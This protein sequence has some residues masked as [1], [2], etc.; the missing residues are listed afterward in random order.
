MEDVV[1]GDLGL[2]GSVSLEV[3][4]ELGAI[5]SSDEDWVIVV[6][7]VFF[8]VIFFAQHGLLFLLY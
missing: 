7:V 2:G 5:A 8:F 3:E 4:G 1:E 6:E